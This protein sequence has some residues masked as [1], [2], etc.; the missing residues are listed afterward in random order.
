MYGLFLLGCCCTNAFPFHLFTHTFSSYCF[1]QLTFMGFQLFCLFNN[2]LYE[3]CHFDKENDFMS[4]K[5]NRNRFVSLM[6]CFRF[7]ALFPCHCVLIFFSY[8]SMLFYWKLHLIHMNYFIW[9]V[10]QFTID[11]FHPSEN[12]KKKKQFDLIKSIK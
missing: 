6:N 8:H 3:Q 12:E 10:N 2:H 7:D 11:A 1:Q 4:K 5:T 9:S